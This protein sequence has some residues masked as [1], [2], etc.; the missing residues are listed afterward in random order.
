[1]F[2][3]L[4]KL[5]SRNPDISGGED[6]YH[7]GDIFTLF[8]SSFSEK[9]VHNMIRLRVCQRFQSDPHLIAKF[10]LHYKKKLFSHNDPLVHF[11]H[12]PEE[13]P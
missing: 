8:Q 5:A 13:S 4:F 10:T 9:G 7:Y 11:I 2:R 1:M 3:L 12:G 6:E